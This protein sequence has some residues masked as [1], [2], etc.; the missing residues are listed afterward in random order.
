MVL[1][2]DSVLT[3]QPIIPL[4]VTTTLQDEPDK[5]DNQCKNWPA[6]VH[7]D[8]ATVTPMWNTLESELSMSHTSASK[9]VNQKQAEH[10]K[11]IIWC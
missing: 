2:I 11:T 1:L 6:I 4:F 9:S 10:L 3:M 8:C 7:V 5:I